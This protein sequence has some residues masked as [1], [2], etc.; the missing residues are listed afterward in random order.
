[1]TQKSVKYTTD[2]SWESYKRLE[3]LPADLPQPS[4]SLLTWGSQHLWRKLL[5]L[6]A[7]ELV[8]DQQVEFLERCWLRDYSPR[9]K[10]VTLRQL[11]ELMD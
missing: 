8:Y 7:D 3:G 6:L 11:W 5:D 9:Q 10:S 4:S 1:M 2:S